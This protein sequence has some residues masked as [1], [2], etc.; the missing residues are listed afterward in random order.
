[1]VGDYLSIALD[2]LFFNYHSDKQNDS[3]FHLLSYN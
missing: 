1:M 2:S 3:Q